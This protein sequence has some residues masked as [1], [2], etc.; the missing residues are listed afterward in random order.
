MIGLSNWISL[1]NVPNIISCL[2]YLAFQQLISMCFGYLFLSISISIYIFISNNI[3][4][5]IKAF[6][7][8]GFKILSKIQFWVIIKFIKFINA[9]KITRKIVIISL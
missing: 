3:A 4:I 1:K 6:S 7:L 2:R 9:T 5:R 8:L